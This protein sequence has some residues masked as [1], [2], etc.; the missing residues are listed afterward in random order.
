M[1]HILCLW[2]R[3]K[4]SITIRRFYF[5]STEY[6]NKVLTI[7]IPNTFDDV[8]PWKWNIS[9]HSCCIHAI[10]IVQFSSFYAVNDDYVDSYVCIGTIQFSWIWLTSTEKGEKF[11]REKWFG[12]IVIIRPH[13][14]IM[15]SIDVHDFLIGLITLGN[16][17]RLSPRKFDIFQLALKKFSRRQSLSQKSHKFTFQLLVPYL[18]TFRERCQLKTF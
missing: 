4:F 6:L 13:Y 12:K 14:V 7:F 1:L 16:F 5:P 9:F 8:K 15:K 2:Q 11:E 18:I 17:F 3:E 10:F